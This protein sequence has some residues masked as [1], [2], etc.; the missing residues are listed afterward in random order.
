MCNK[1]G[2]YPY[3][4]RKEGGTTVLRFFPKNP[5]AKYPDSVVFVLSLDREGK[6]KLSKIIS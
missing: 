3:K 1:I 5:E 6:D 2:G 4:V